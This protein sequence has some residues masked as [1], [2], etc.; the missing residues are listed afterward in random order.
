MA[1]AFPA[2]ALM[3]AEAFGTAAV[4]M[5]PPDADDAVLEPYPFEAI[6]VKV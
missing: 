3:L 4:G 5:I 6:T 1:E 2:T